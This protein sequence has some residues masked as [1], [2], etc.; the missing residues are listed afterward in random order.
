[1]EKKNKQ[2]GAALLELLVG[3]LLMAL[4]ATTLFAIMSTMVKSW[5]ESSSKLEVLHT[6][7]YVV[8]SMV[9]ELRYADQYVLESPTRL[10]FRNKGLGGTVGNTYCY[11]L[12]PVDRKM[13]RMGP[14]ASP[15]PMSGANVAGAS[16]V[17][18]YAGEN[19]LFVVSGSETAE[20][21]LIAVDSM[22]GQRVTIH[23]AVTGIT[24]YLK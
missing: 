1:M 8:D 7:R 3:I 17:E 12:S 16:T 5:R 19:G 4:V 6:A 10:T 18:L 15:Q 24:D 13:Y 14:D 9:R 23:A 20:I 2:K 22:S 21:T 11:Y